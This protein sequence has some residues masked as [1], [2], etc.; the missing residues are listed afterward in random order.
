MQLENTRRQNELK[1]YYDR[2]WTNLVVK[3]DGTKL[4]YIVQEIDKKWANFQ[5]GSKTLKT[6]HF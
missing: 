4:F 5:C 6:K 1:I 3:F 2:G